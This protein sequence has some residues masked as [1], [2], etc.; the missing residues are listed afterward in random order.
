[1]KFHVGRYDYTQDI[2][3]IQALGSK[4]AFTNKH[5]S[6]PLFNV[7]RKTSYDAFYTSST[8]NETISQVYWDNIYVCCT[9]V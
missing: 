2:L 8:W 6:V 5:S 7:L 9:F 4:Q 1:M 3:R